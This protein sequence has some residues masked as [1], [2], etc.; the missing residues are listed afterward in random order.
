MV[1]GRVTAVEAGRTFGPASRP[2][3]YA[4]VRVAVVELLAGS[5]P[6]PQAAEV[7]LEIPL[8]GGLEQL[9]PLRLRLLGSERLLFLRSKGE[10][11]RRAGLSAEARAADAPFHRLMTFTSELVAVDGR[12]AV[13]EGA[14]ALLPLSGLP[15][16]EAVA[17]IREIGEVP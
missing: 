12:V 4:T 2:L 9:D 17:R 6:R 1:H 13:P 5:L 11:A 16:A 14:R 3:P 7:A 15:F 10:T 8:F